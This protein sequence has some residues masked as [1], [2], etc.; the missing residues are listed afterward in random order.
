MLRCLISSLFALLFGS[1]KATG[2][3]GDGPWI[4]AHR[5]ASG[6]A[7]EHTHDAYAIAHRQG[8]DFIEQDIVLTRDGVPIVLHDIHLEIATNVGDR[9][10]DR[11]RE[12][13][14]FYAIDFFWEEIRQLHKRAPIDLVTGTTR[15]PGRE[16][17]SRR[18]ARVMSF[19][20]SIEWIEAL[21]RETGRKVGI[22]PEI[23][24]P[25]FHSREGKDIVAA[26]LQVLQDFGYPD[27][28]RHLYLQSFD[29]KALQRIRDKWG[30]DVRLVQLIG[31][32]HWLEAEGTDFEAM[33]SR[34]GL[35]RVAEYA[36]AI[37]PHWPQ[38]LRDTEWKPLDPEMD[39][40]DP[41]WIPDNN[42]L[43]PGTMAEEARRL[44]LAIY[45]FTLRLE[46]LPRWI[47]FQALHHKLIID[48]RVDGLFTDFPDLSKKIRDG[49][50][51]RVG[52]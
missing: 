13:G 34:E 32:N 48:L 24:M 4:I 29:P 38:L 47:S 21:N 33:R 6:Y 18:P 45:P 46:G 50:C 10:P 12:D 51:R 22:F 43:V 44:G 37:G 1:G 16:L 41:E 27:G 5:G 3:E 26:V 39:E 49:I 19:A 52:N 35:R 15:Y 25:R 8:A 23:K 40:I 2:M 14:H 42:R 17:A 9:F 28:A 11:A 36:D 31:E 20:E 30:G 7:I